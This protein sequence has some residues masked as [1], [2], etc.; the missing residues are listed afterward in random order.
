MSFY[1]IRNHY[2]LSVANFRILFSVK[3][4]YNIWYMTYPNL[5]ASCNG[6][7]Q[8]ISIHFYWLLFF[9]QRSVIATRH[10]FYF[11]T[12]H[13]RG[14]G[15]IIASRLLFHIRLYRFRFDIYH[16]TIGNSTLLNTLIM[17]KKRMTKK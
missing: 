2:F 6:A 7:S 16:R 1:N 3:I 5:M 12:M 8:G 17:V 9:L 10:C 13:Y 15:L 4:G 14:A 11:F